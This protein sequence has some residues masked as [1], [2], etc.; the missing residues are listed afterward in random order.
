MAERTRHPPARTNRIRGRI[1]RE[2]TRPN[3]TSGPSER[4]T[5]TI[6]SLVFSSR[7]PT[8]VPVPCLAHTAE[9]VGRGGRDGTAIRVQLRAAAAA[10]SLWYGR[11]EEGQRHRPK[12]NHRS[13]SE[14]SR[15]PHET[16]AKTKESLDIYPRPR[17]AT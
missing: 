17:V 5:G 13:A 10:T 6:P 16:G 3:P 7:T 1:C 14:R 2:I 11:Y 12:R 8:Q 9:Y 15:K 4:L